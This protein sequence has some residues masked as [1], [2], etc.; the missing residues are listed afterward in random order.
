[1]YRLGEASYDELLS[2]V[3]L[4]SFLGSKKRAVA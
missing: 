1:M 2:S 4:W 3:F